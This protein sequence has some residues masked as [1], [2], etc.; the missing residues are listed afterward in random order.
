M[1]PQDEA[2][3][4]QT[5]AQMLKEAAQDPSALDGR[6]ARSLQRSGA[7]LQK[8]GAEG[9]HAAALQRLRGQVSKLCGK[10]GLQPAQRSACEAIL[11]TA[12]AAKAGTKP[13]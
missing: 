4:E 2:R 10:A 12:T 3:I 11:P 9:Q 7:Q 1:T 6:S 5:L 8:W 13:V